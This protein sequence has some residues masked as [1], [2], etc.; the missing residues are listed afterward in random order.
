LCVNASPTS[1][2]EIG[3]PPQLLQPAV[4]PY[5]PTTAPTLVPLEFLLAFSCPHT[6][7][8]ILYIN[9]RKISPL[10][11]CVPSTFSLII[12]NLLLFVLTA[13]YVSS[14][15]TKAEPCSSFYIALI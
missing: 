3:G 1:H 10:P 9:S 15:R 11:Y 12:L 6:S 5:P 14:L 4:Q 13:V 2:L 7:T 8:I